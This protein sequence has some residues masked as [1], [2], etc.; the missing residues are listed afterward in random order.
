MKIGDKV[1]FLSESGGG[2]IAGFQGNKIVLVEDEDGFQIPTPITEV[3]VIEDNN[4]D[5]KAIKSIEQHAREQA[6]E[7][8]NKS[9]KQRLSA[10]DEEDLTNWRD[11]DIVDVAPSDDPSVGFEA[12]K[13]ERPG[14]NKLS[15]YLAFVPIDEAQ[16]ETTRFESYFV[17]DSNYSVYFTYQTLN[18]SGKWQLRGRGEVAP[19]MKLKIE[20]F[21]RDDLNSMLKGDVQ[22]QAYK[23]DKD[24]ELKSPYDVQVKLDA[25]KFFK[26][27]A[28]RENP[29]FSERSI[30]Y[31]LVENDR[32][33]H[34]TN[35][36]VEESLIELEDKK[37]TEKATPSTKIALDDQALTDLKS[38]FSSPSPVKVANK[39]K[40]VI[41][42]DK[43]VIDL[44]IDEL[45]D[46]TVGMS[47]SDI[48][49]YQLNTFR[50]VLEQYKKDKGQKLIFIHGKGEGVLR[51]AIIHEL[52]YKYKGYF[53]QDASFREYGY[54]ATQ[55]TIQ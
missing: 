11:I 36:S 39:V 10:D 50:N 55:V 40:Q 41:K 25:V 54:G 30:L 13:V 21:S 9:V 26:L 46:T 8:L 43:I 33:A 24:F 4:A 23:Q 2:I 7:E 52:N 14:G 17:N 53:Y 38:H 20:E 47:S 51:R 12:P 1:R 16:L 32:L 29:F 19:N 15:I 27:N 6:S 5:A 44:H 31:T 48:L 22:F 28:F 18:E 35:V 37:V 45:L 3:V 49:E 34:G 42:E